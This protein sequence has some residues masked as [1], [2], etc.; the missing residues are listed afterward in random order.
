MKV[1]FLDIDGVLNSFPELT[2]PD[3]PNHVWSPDVMKEF[4]ISFDVQEDKVELLNR[5]TDATG[6]KIVLSSSWRKGYLADYADVVTELHNKGMKSFVLDR[7][8]W[9]SEYKNRG[10]E[11]QAWYNQHE[12][13]IESFIILDD[14]DDMGPVQNHLIQTKHWEGL[15]D[16][17]V[18]TAIEY[19]GR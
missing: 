18:E 12:D 16:H 10:E 17:H 7:T 14:H 9:G 19:L 6:A 3:I 11:I 1:I 2:N 4:G 15:Q 8:P 5:I 13:E